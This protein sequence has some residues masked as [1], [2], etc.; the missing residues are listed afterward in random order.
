[1]PHDNTVAFAAFAA[2]AGAV[3]GTPAG[4]GDGA[5]LGAANKT[6]LPSQLQCRSGWVFSGG[7]CGAAVAVGFQGGRGR[8]VAVSV[9]AYAVAQ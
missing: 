4:S 8:T 5:V 2:S 6:Q 7:H 3:P 9:V 1:M